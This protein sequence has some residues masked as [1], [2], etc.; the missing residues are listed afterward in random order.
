[1]EKLPTIGRRQPP[2]K[3][4]HDTRPEVIVQGV[5]EEMLKGRQ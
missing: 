5:D 1:M 2:Y 4:G 3:R